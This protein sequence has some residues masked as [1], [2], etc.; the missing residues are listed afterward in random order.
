MVNLN[1]REKGLENKFAHDEEVKFKI[2]SRRRKLLGLWAAELMGLSDEDSLYYARD[3]IS[4]GIEDNTPGA[5]IRKIMN[6]AQENGVKL[7]ESQVR[8]K[9]SEFEVMATKQIRGEK[10]Q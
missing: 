4:F 9:N 2:A 10:K 1:D 8:I 5:V 6:D 3:V 7:T